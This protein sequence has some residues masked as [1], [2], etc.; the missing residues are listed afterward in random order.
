MR[1]RQSSSW[2]PWAAGRSVRRGR[3]PRRRAGHR[4]CARSSPSSIAV[5][6]TACSAPPGFAYSCTRRTSGGNSPLGPLRAPRSASST[7]AAEAARTASSAMVSSRP[8]RRQTKRRRTASCTIRKIPFRTRRA[9]SASG[10][11]VRADQR[12]VEARA[13]V[14]CYSTQPLAADLE[15]AGPVRLVL[16]AASSAPDTDFTAKLVDVAPDG[17]AAHRCEGIVRARRQAED[18]TPIWF[19]ANAPRRF[20]IDLWATSCRFR[21]GHRIRLEVSSS[22]FPRFD[23]NPNT[24][25]EPGDGRPRAFLGGPADGA[26]RR[27]TPV[28]AR[29]SRSHATDSEAKT[30]RARRRD[31]RRALYPI[32]ARRLEIDGLQGLALVPDGARLGIGDQTANGLVEGSVELAT[33][34]ALLRRGLGASLGDD[35][36]TPALLRGPPSSSFSLPCFLPMS[37]SPQRVPASTP[38]SFRTPWFSPADH[39]PS[40]DGIKRKTHSR[41]GEEADSGHSSSRPFGP[42]P[43]LRAE[44]SVMTSPTSGLATGD[45]A[46]PREIGVGTRRARRVPTQP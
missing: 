39:R 32:A 34:V 16:F 27:R 46:T 3:T 10:D 41:S 6:A 30:R 15:V 18:E 24:R 5:C 19:E 33:D 25:D 37:R 2:G 29:S 11:G 4:A 31:R 13:D 45:R 28:T 20:E 1:P 21:A 12:P 42:R 8:R 23:R 26:P 44:N 9:A 14:L 7:C 35:E 22:N 40:L 38:M 43:S 17:S 36:I